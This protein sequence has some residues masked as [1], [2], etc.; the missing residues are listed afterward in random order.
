MPA[1]RDE[2]RF[3]PRDALNREEHYCKDTISC[4]LKSLFV[5]GVMCSVGIML[6][7]DCSIASQ[8]PQWWIDRGVIKTNAAVTNDYAGVVAGQLKNFAT[9]A[10]D[11]LE[12]KLP[13]GAGTNVWARVNSF[14]LS[15]NFCVVNAGQLKAL[16][17]PF[18]DRLIAVGYTNAYAWPTPATGSD[19]AMVNIGQVKNVLCF[20]LS[21]LSNTN[22][23]DG[24]GMP[25]A[26]ENQLTNATNISIDQ[27]LPGDDADG[28]GV[29]NYDEWRLGTNPLDPASRPP[30]ASFSSGT[31]VVQRMEST[32][33]L[34]LVILPASAGSLTLHVARTGGS[35]VAGSEYN[36]T[37]TDVV[38]N[39][40]QTNVPV[41]FYVHAPTNQLPD[42]S[43]ELTL[44]F[45][46]GNGV[47][48]GATG[49]TV[50]LTGAGTDSDADG[51]PDWWE[52][53]YFGNLSQTGAGDPDAD[54]YT[55]LQE[56]QNGTDPTR[57]DASGTF[58]DTD[59]S[60]LTPL[61]S[62]L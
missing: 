22:D 8:Y 32:N 1:E 13:G 50:T 45:K 25:D 29:S 36:F 10:A 11:E 56:Y 40:G 5:V 4:R 41:L 47:V 30:V 33:Q 12:S 26:W 57:F 37:D 61:R 16:T 52:Y 48:G 14:S 55:N 59:F 24:D 15:N 44:T 19:F 46:T 7:A 60:L 54:G 49:C 38:V 43:V 9:K 39:A 21:R 17:K 35:A 42:K 34:S 3:R 27:V 18:W 31:M 51:L 62:G 53:K 2:D 6:S 20:D 23:A 28:D 58:S